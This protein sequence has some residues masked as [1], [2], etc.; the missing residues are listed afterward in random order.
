MQVP[1]PTCSL[2]GCKTSFHDLLRRECVLTRLVLEKHLG[3][4]FHLIGAH[5][6][7]QVKV[8]VDVLFALEEGAEIFAIV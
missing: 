2:L 6:L 3:A 1:I 7:L 5:L 8:Q 4:V